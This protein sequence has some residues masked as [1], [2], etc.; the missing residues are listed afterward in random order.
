ME[1]NTLKEGYPVKGTNTK[2]YCQKFKLKNDPKLIEEYKY[3]HDNRNIWPE[4]PRGIKEVG[5]LNMEIYIFGT[6]LF[7]IMDVPG[8]FDYEKDMQILGKLERQEEWEKFM[9]NFQDV[10]PSGIK[11]ELMERIYHLE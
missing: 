7:M 6:D 11:W 10:P 1:K 3:W 5:I 4:I 2:R 9:A 8:D